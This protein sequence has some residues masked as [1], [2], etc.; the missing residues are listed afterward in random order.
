MDLLEFDVLTPAEEGRPMTFLHPATLKPI[1]SKEDGQP[2]TVTLRGL[3][4]DLAREL[5][6]Q[7]NDAIAHMRERQVRETERQAIAR[8]V[9]LLAQM[10]V[11]W[12]SN[13]T[14][15]GERM[16]FSLENARKLWGDDRFAAFRE[17]ALIFIDRDSSFIKPSA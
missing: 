16:E 11:G 12:S 17:Q 10:T 14:I 4:C 15:G 9:E 8:S 6:K 1:L 13:F 7:Q 2:I 3:R 5:L